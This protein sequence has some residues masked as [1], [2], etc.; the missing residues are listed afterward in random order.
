[1]SKIY[2][3]GA[4]HHIKE[5]EDGGSI[6]LLDQVPEKGEVSCVTKCL[7]DKEQWCDVKDEIFELEYCC[8]AGVFNQDKDLMVS[9]IMALKTDKT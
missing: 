7:C 9:K 1:M 6:F 4:I 8:V 3:I 2:L 5:T